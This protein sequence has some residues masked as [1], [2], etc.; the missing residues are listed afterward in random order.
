VR[1]NIELYEV[2]RTHRQVSVEG[3]LLDTDMPSAPPEELSLCSSSQWM[4][5]KQSLAEQKWEPR[6]MPNLKRLDL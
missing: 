5:L 2:D 4:S 3:Y 6:E 1:Q